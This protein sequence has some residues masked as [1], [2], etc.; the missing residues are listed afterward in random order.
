MNKKE[1]TTLIRNLAF[2]FGECVSCEWLSPDGVEWLKWKNAEISV[3]F[4]IDLEKGYIRNIHIPNTSDGIDII[5][6]ETAKTILARSY[7]GGHICIKNAT[8]A[9]E[10]AER[11]MKDKAID[12]LIQ[13]TVAFPNDTDIKAFEEQKKIFL[14]KL[15]S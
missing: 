13:S 12:A 10:T 5:K 15:N 7:D 4:L 3:Q 8:E 6:S 1:L 14:E 9:V 11:E 2:H